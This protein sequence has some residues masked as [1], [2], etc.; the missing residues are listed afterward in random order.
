[1]KQGADVAHAIDRRVSSELEYYIT[2]HLARLP[3][4][5]RRIT[6]CCVCFVIRGPT[7]TYSRRYIRRKTDEDVERVR[8]AC[9]DMS[10]RDSLA[11]RDA[12]DAA[13][14]EAMKAAQHATDVQVCLVICMSR[15]V[16]ALVL[17]YFTAAA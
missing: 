3:C 13:Q 6:C 12:R 2:S 10:Q 9:A 16:F 8:L 17:T 1:M 5:V 14:A 15:G 4:I 7:V 11:A